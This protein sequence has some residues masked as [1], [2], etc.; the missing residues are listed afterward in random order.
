MTRDSETYHSMISRAA[1]VGR[2]VQEVIGQIPDVLSTRRDLRID[3]EQSVV[4]AL[5][6]YSAK[7]QISLPLGA[8]DFRPFHITLF[9]LSTNCRRSHIS[10]GRS[11]T[12]SLPVKF[13]SEVGGSNDLKQC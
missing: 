8:F 10:T 13:F 5:Q 6:M 11:I 7:S 9:N 3:A 12:A 2:T 4:G 1:K